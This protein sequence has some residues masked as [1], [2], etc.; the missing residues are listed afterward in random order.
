MTDNAEIDENYAK[1][2]GGMTPDEKAQ[3][4]ET[5]ASDSMHMM[6]ELER[7]TN[8]DFDIESDNVSNRQLARYRAFNQA[9]SDLVGRAYELAEISKKQN[10]KEAA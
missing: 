5:Y 4:F 2:I 3:A 8:A 7:Y 1:P 6:E 10:Q 9:L